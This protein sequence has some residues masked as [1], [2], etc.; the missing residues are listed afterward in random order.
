METEQ[1]LRGGR[2]RALHTE[3]AKPASLEWDG[4]GGAKKIGGKAG[5]ARAGGAPPR[6]FRWAR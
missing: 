3:R 5:P 4:T 1:E 2:E 6:T